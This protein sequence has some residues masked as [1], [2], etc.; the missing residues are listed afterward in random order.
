MFLKK[1]EEKKIKIQAKKKVKNLKLSSSS[2]SIQKT[3]FD[4]SIMQLCVDIATQGV[5][6][7]AFAGESFQKLIE[8]AK[9]GA[10]DSS[11]YKINPSN[12]KS[13]V[14]KCASASDEE[15]KKKMKNKLISFSADLATCCNRSF[16]GNIY[17]FMK[18]QLEN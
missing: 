4:G 15:I 16:F 5:P 9:K 11:P 1:K 3:I 7:N 14:Y 18:S 17:I 12:I 6:F 8:Y 10:N 13:E 2:S